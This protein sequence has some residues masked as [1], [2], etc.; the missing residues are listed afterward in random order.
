[1][2][3][4]EVTSKQFL[5]QLQ[6]L[7]HRAR[8]PKPFIISQPILN[9]RRNSTGS[10]QLFGPYKLPDG[11][12][13]IKYPVTLHSTPRNLQSYTLVPLSKRI[14]HIHSLRRSFLPQASVPSVLDST[15]IL[16]EH[17]EGTIEYSGDI[18]DQPI[19][20]RIASE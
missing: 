15:P 14:F 12:R 3:E 13:R 19:L 4:V 8:S 6:N 17:R 16:S 20:P 1:M 9:I 10:T 7:A 2:S 18:I 11:F 5:G